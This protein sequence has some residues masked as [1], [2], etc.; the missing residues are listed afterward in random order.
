MR[1][2]S[3]AKVSLFPELTKFSIKKP[4]KS[5]SFL[6]RENFFNYLCPK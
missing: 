1:L 4:L 3:G 5:Y 2:K 6:A